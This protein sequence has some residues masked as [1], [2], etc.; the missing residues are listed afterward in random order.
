MSEVLIGH[1]FAGRYELQEFVGKGGMS[2]VYRALDRNTGHQVAVKLLKPE[3][4]GDKEFLARFEREALAAG[5]MRHHNIVNLLD[6]GNEDGRRFLVMEYVEGRTLKEI[7]T[8]R[9]TLPADTAAQV[10]IRILSAL[11]H[12]HNNGII[13]R[14][15][16]PQ[17]ILVSPDGMIKVA[18]F[19]IARVA[20]SD[21][22]TKDDAVLGSVHY[23][24]PE[25]AKG[26]EVNAASD[27][28]S[29]GVV[30]YEMLTGHVP[31]EG[32]TAVSI[33]MQHISAEPR[34][35]STPK[36]PV[37]PAMEA[38]VLRALA[39]APNDRYP[40][41]ASM[42]RAIKSALESPSVPPVAVPMG[43]GTF[44]T[45]GIQQPILVTTPT[46]APVHKKRF[47]RHLPVL[48]LSVVLLSALTA[49]AILLTRSIVSTVEAP[50][51]VGETEAT[52]L[53][54]GDE[55]GL[56]IEVLR[57]SDDTTPAGVV[58]LQSRAYGYQM[59]RGDVLVITVS[60]GPALQ[61]VPTLK[62]S[63]LSAARTAAQKYGFTVL[64]TR[65][66]PSELSYGTV[67]TQSPEAGSML[68]SGEIIQVTV[69]GSIT[70]P[71]M[72]GE[73]RSAALLLAQDAGFDHIEI[74][75][76]P[77]ADPAQVDTVISQSPRAGERVLYDS[78]ITLLVY[79]AP[80]ETTAAPTSGGNP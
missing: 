6:V 38:V 27:L 12:A 75:E 57:Q 19:G 47:V 50:Y 35:L 31:F 7:I 14:D 21:T 15:I 80:A 58:I 22:L 72:E 52:A 11:Q 18:D 60:T 40:D 41:A 59:K 49:A 32:D 70:V 45:S 33:A 28:Y 2:L 13:H 64:V 1:L 76:Y 10:A 78:T 71:L 54:I 55:K 26:E 51:L 56:V 30:M 63:T 20:G 66:E 37:S 3:L 74:I 62:G 16:K 65:M 68:A 29:V 77:A 42:A 9:T 17:N 8:E 23:F 4:T 43:T 53:R 39:K 48:I 73:K 24:S 5:K 46:P 61:G 36:H 79:A 44:T 34:R 25:Q 67:L 69:S